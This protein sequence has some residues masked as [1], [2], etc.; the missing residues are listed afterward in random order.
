MKV[1][2]EFF[3]IVRHHHAR[4]FV[5]TNSRLIQRMN[6]DNMLLIIMTEEEGIH[7]IKVEKGREKI[8]SIEETSSYCAI[9]CSIEVPQTRVWISIAAN[10]RLAERV[11]FEPTIPLPV[12]HLSR[13]ANSTAL[14]PLQDACGL[15]AICFVVRNIFKNFQASEFLFCSSFHQ[16]LRGTHM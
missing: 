6:G 10:N 3:V 5:Y 2:E 8:N 15:H 13:V 1:W 14:A 7:G 16:K 12:Y 4:S 9:A 11:G